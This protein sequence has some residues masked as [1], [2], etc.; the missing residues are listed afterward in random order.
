MTQNVTDDGAAL[1]APSSVTLAE[2]FAALALGGRIALTVGDPVSTTTLTTGAA[3]PDS[4]VSPNGPSSFTLT[5]NAGGASSSSAASGSLTM[6][7]AQASAYAPIPSFHPCNAASAAHAAIPAAATVPVTTVPVTT[8]PVPAVP[9]TSIPV[10]SVPTAAPSA[11]PPNGGVSQYGPIEVN[12][13]DE[14][15]F[16]PTLRWYAITR[17]RRVGVFA[18]WQNVAPYVVSV[19]GAVYA[20]FPSRAQAEV[21]FADAIRNG[22]VMILP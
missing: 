11:N 12:E 19:S 15:D 14:E 8:V 22:L 1:A 5:L 18:R 7:S 6:A 2:L 10:A 21:A 16:D 20:R 17:G 4:L 13:S 3:T 9:V